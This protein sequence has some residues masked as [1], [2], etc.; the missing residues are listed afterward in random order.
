MIFEKNKACTMSPQLLS[1]SSIGDFTDYFS[2]GE[3]SSGFINFYVNN[4]IDMTYRT[5]E[6]KTPYAVFY[7]NFR[8]CGTWM[9]NKATLA[10]DIKDKTN[11][12]Y[13]YYLTGTAFGNIH[14]YQRGSNIQKCLSGLTQIVIQIAKVWER[15]GWDFG[16]NP[17]YEQTNYLSLLTI[18]YLT[19]SGSLTHFAF[20]SYS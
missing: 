10:S 11:Y 4:P 20:Q 14:N 6:T 1:V 5:D 19:D 18:D 15:K 9:L 13:M 8:F 17:I 12:S 7:K 16:G 2:G 3:P